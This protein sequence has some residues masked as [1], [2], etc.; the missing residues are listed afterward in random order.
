MW[1]APVMTRILYHSVGCPYCNGNA[2]RVRRGS[3]TIWSIR[4]TLNPK[5][6]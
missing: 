5:T 4:K 1:G 6:L 2:L 3:F